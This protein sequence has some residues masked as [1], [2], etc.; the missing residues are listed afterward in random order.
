MICFD[1]KSAWSIPLVLSKH[2]FLESIF[3]AF[4]IIMNATMQ[5]LFTVIIMSPDFLGEGLSVQDARTWRLRFA[6]DLD[7]VG[8][9]QRNLASI[10]CD[11]DGALIFSTAQVAQLVDINNYLGLDKLSFELPNFQSLGTSFW[12]YGPYVATATCWAHQVKPNVSRFDM[13]PGQWT[14]TCRF[15]RFKD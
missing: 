12:S 3:G 13:F 10:V 1:R 9:D 6:H 4:L 11:E 5:V 14:C 7:F 8:L 2:N 15:C